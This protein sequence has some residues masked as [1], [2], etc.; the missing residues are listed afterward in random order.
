MTRTST[1][2][3]EAVTQRPE[4]RIN[5][6]AVQV[7]AKRKCKLQAG[8]GCRGHENLLVPRRG[9]VGCENLLVP[10]RGQVGCGW[11]P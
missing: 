11:S 3:I 1:A 6:T 8:S 9:Q 2:N 4:Q 7:I 10:R 5:K